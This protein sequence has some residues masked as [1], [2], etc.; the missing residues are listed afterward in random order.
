[1]KKISLSG[2]IFIG[3]AFGIILGMVI[4]KFQLDFL[5]LNVIQPIGTIKKD[6]R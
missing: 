4:N 6:I 3:L 2:K 1:M 5:R